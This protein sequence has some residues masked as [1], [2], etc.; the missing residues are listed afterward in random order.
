MPMPT[1]G[2]YY[3]RQDYY[4]ALYLRPYLV[5]GLVITAIGSDLPPLLLRHWN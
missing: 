3:A 4:D 1:L 2:D 5:A